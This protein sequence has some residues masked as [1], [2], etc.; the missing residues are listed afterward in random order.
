MTKPI[1]GRGGR[2]AGSVGSGKNDVPTASAA[3]R[4]SSTDLGAAYEASAATRAASRGCQIVFGDSV[5]ECRAAARDDREAVAVTFTYPRGTDAS[6]IAARLDA[7]GVPYTPL[8]AYGAPEIRYAGWTVS[9]E[10]T[11]E[12]EVVS[13]LLDN[14]DAGWAQA[15][16]VERAVR[17][18]WW[19]RGPAA[20]V[21]AEVGDRPVP[22]YR[23]QRILESRS[24]AD[25]LKMALTETGERDTPYMVWN[26]RGRTD[27]PG[28]RFTTLDQAREHLDL[29]E[30]G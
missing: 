12:F 20:R 15:R 13:P 2:F 6:E 7:A 3:T 9:S 24:G 17:G 21:A 10:P 16:D 25:G 29:T 22:R 26:A 8:A 14:S 30:R 18:R 28:I 19:R 11:G 27:T 23:G 4:P 5:A 1:R